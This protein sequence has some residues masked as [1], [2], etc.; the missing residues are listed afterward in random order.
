MRIANGYLQQSMLY[1]QKNNKNAAGNFFDVMKKTSERVDN[2]ISARDS[3]VNSTD[4]NYFGIDTKN[5]ISQ[6]MEFPIETDRYKIEDATY[7]NGVAAYEIVDKQTG[8]DL[9]I[10]EDQLTIQRDE[11]TGMEFL[12]NMDQPFSYNIT[13]TGELKYLLNDLSEKRN[14]DIKEIPLQ[15]GLVVNHDPKTGLNYLSIK[16]NEAQGVSVILTSEKDIET[17][18]KLVDEFQEYS[19]SSQRSTAG[20]YALL[21]ISGNLKREKDGFTFLTPNGITYIPY[22]GDSGKAWEM[23]MPGS[24]YATA[25]KCLAAENDCADISTWTKRLNGIK[26]YDGDNYGT[27]WANHAYKVDAFGRNCMFA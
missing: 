7:V 8:K 10:R 23:D 16:G 24:C 18:N 2:K 3:Y 21:E 9:Y 11:K 12:I 14:I 5:S 13:M 6:E 20:L 19:V 1:S 17:L 26:I 22:D 15:G 4:D 25:R 27:A